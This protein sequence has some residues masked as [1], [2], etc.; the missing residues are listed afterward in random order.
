MYSVECRSLV[1]AP[2]APPPQAR[3]ARRHVTHGPPARHGGV[4]L[5]F[6]ST[7]ETRRATPMH[8]GF[9]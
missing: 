5:S 9:P 7:M 1:T 3:A 8:G 4:K 2:E 6:S